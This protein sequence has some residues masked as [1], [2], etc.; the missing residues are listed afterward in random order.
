LIFEL[1]TSA[2]LIALKKEIAEIRNTTLNI[3]VYEVMH[4]KPKRRFRND[5]L[6]STICSR[7]GYIV[8]SHDKAPK[9]SDF[10]NVKKQIFSDNLEKNFFFCC[11]CDCGP[12]AQHLNF[13]T[14]NSTHPSPQ[15]LQYL[16][17]V[18]V[19][20]SGAD[21][22][23]EIF[24]RMGTFSL[25]CLKKKTFSLTVQVLVIKEKVEKFHFK[26]FLTPSL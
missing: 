5:D 14:E 23:L 8:A 15:H 21:S 25:F 17:R 9:D 16:G 12:S 18:L 2:Q 4:G 11:V 20:L 1:S 10:V 24:P 7:T 3:E 19:L 13:G 26:T 22:R 6:L